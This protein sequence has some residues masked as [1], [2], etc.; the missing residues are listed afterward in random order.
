MRNNSTICVSIHVY[1]AR[2]VIIDKS[3]IALTLFCLDY[4]LCIK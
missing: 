1:I 2:S 4:N 3:M